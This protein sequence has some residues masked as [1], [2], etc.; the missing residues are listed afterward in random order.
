MYKVRMKVGGSVFPF[1]EKLANHSEAIVID[2]DEAGKVIREVDVSEWKHNVV[3]DVQAEVVEELP[4]TEDY[5]ADAEL[6]P[7]AIPVDP[8]DA[9]DLE[10]IDVDAL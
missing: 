1:T 6:E 8:S 5:E 4:Q 9:I 2:V 3:A 10:S 7:T